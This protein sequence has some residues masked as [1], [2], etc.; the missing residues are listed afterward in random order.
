[1]YSFK[2]EGQLLR[3]VG[4]SSVAESFRNLELPLFIRKEIEHYCERIN[5]WVESKYGSGLDNTTVR[6]PK[7]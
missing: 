6:I 2:V 7:I 3:S 5:I 4:E 1:M